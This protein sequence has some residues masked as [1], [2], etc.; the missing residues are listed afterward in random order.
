MLFRNGGTNAV[1]HVMERAGNGSCPR[2]RSEFWWDGVVYA[3]PLA[4]GRGY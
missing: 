1:S 3:V 2:G 4:G